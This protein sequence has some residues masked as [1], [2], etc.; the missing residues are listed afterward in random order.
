[1][2][3]WKCGQTFGSFASSFANFSVIILGSIELKRILLIPSTY[4]P[5]ESGRED[6]FFS[7]SIVTQNPD[8]SSDSQ[9]H[10]VG[11]CMNSGQNYFLIAGIRK[12]FH[13]FYDFLR[14]AAVIDFFLPADPDFKFH[15]DLGKQLLRRG[16]AEPS[17]TFSS[18][19]FLPCFSRISGSRSPSAEDCIVSPA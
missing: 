2:D 11:T 19:H 18:S 1:M 8:P 16:D 12:P 4:G 6:L 15:A 13:F 14:D 17:I 9:I 5:A 3:R 7:P 10:P